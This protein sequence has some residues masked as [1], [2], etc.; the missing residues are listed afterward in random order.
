MKKKKVKRVNKST[1]AMK[2]E[3]E[4][5]LLIFNNRLWNK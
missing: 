4:K 2:K 1:E 3:L 5:L